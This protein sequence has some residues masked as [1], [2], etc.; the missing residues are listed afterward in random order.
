MNWFFSLDWCDSRF[1]RYN[2]WR[3]ICHSDV[4]RGMGCSLDFSSGMVY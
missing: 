4:G 1:A 2:N 3:D